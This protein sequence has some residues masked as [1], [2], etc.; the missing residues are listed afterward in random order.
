M[1]EFVYSDIYSK[2]DELSERERILRAELHE[3]RQQRAHL[4]SQCN[5]SFISERPEWISDLPQEFWYP[6]HVASKI[7]SDLSPNLRNRNVPADL[8]DWQKTSGF[9]EFVVNL[10]LTLGTAIVALQLF[11]ILF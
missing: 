8:V 10:G 11:F 5:Y 3:V 9:K 6:S 2:I 1:S 7:I 4:K